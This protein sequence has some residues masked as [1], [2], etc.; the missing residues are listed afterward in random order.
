MSED[1]KFKSLIQQLENLAEDFNN[2]P[3]EKSKTIADILDIVAAVSISEYKI[4]RILELIR[5]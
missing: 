2:Q 1:L 5:T 4:D 3:D